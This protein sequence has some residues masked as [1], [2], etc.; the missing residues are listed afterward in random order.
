MSNK[1]YQKVKNFIPEV[2]WAVYEPLVEKINRLKAEKNAGN[3][4][5]FDPSIN[6]ILLPHPF[7]TSISYSLFSATPGI[8]FIFQPPLQPP[9]TVN[10]LEIL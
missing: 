5:F 2:E 6:S 10:Y 1:L 9:F 8:R 4:V 3:I 7:L